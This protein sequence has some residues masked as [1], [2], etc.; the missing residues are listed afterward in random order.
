MLIGWLL[1]CLDTGGGGADGNC[2]GA[3]ICGGCGAGR[4]N[5][6]AEGGLLGGGGGGGGGAD[7]GEACPAARMA[8]WTAREGLTPLDGGKDGGVGGWGGCG[9]SERGLPF[10]GGRGAD[11]DG[12]GGGGGA[13]AEGTEGAAEGGRGGGPEVTFEDG[14]RDPGGGGGFFPIGGGGPRRDAEEAGLGPA[15]PRVLR[16]FATEGTTPGAVP[17]LVAGGR[18]FGSG[19]AAPVG[20]FGAAAAGGLGADVR[21]DSG[22]DAYVESLFAVHH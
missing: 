10:I 12:G 1:R 19:G 6:G 18:L 4:E 9:A 14:F 15:W 20:I 8:A 21:E 16:R 2:G 5:D 17:T 11:T 13:G 7:D 22:S 3:S